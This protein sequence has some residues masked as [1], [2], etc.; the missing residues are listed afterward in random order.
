LKPLSKTNAV[1]RPQAKEVRT[2]S[3]QIKIAGSSNFSKRNSVS[4]N[5]F[6]LL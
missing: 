2:E 6:S 5:L 1:E 4:F 3:L